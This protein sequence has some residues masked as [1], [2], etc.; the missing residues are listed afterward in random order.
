M[1]IKHRINTCNWIFDCICLSVKHIGHHY[2]WTAQC[3][4]LRPWFWQVLKL[5]LRCKDQQHLWSQMYELQEAMKI[6]GIDWKYSILNTEFMSLMIRQNVTL[7]QCCYYSS[8]H[9]NAIIL[10]FCWK[11][12]YLCIYPG[13]WDLPVLLM[14]R[15]RGSCK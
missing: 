13:K 1:N 15:C 3:H 11:Q 2:K 9:T 10:W 5:K 8:G 14:L 7:L 6:Q 12:C 4:K